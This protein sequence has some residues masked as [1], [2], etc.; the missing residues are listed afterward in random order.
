MENLVPIAAIVLSIGGPL[1]IAA[2]VIIL[3]HK[4]QTMLNQMISSAVA[5]GRSPDEVREIV[6]A[7]KG[8]R[9]GSSGKRS[10]RTGI[11][12]VGIGFGLA[13][14]F[15]FTGDSVVLGASGFVVLLGLAFVAVW[16]LVDRQKNQS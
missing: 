10:L 11:I 15:P 14:M 13:L 9:S 1:A 16:L 6:E 12:L 2:T 8:R 4:Q 7:V 5:A 3:Q